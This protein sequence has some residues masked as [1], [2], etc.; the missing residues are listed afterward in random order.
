VHT[1][2]FHSLVLKKVVMAIT[3]LCLI[4]FLLMH[5]FGNLKA[6]IGADA[7]NHYAEW[8]KGE[9]D[10]NVG[11][12]LEPILPHGW[13][14]WIF[15]VFMLACLVLHIYCAVKVWRASVQG[16]GAT[17]G[18]KYTRVHRPER[19]IAARFMRWGGLALLLLLVF[20]ILM[21]T[22]KTIRFGFET[23]STPYDM[24]TASFSSAHWY[25]F[26]IYLVFMAVVCLHVRHGFYS[27]FTTLGANVSERARG[28]LN[29]LAYFVATLIFVGFLLPPAASVLG[30]LGGN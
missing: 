27:A 30:F 20:H 18:K 10:D 3:G 16:R 21:F 8:L 6:F 12:V 23:N 24:F 15:R 25:V 11:G 14:I 19:T 1:R 7:Y 26:V 13:F 4:G 17:Q 2:A 9:L 5:M 22:T 29:G 28:V